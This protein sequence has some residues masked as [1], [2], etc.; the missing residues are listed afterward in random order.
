MFAVGIPKK[1]KISRIKNTVMT[2]KTDDLESSF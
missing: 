2:V 1:D